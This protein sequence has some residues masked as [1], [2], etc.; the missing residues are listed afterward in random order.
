MAPSWAVPVGSLLGLVAVGL[1]FV[2]WFFPHAWKKG[3]QAERDLVDGL[4]EETRE[5]RIKYNRAIIKRYEKRLARERGE[6]VDDSD[7]D[8]EMQAPEPPP[9]AYVPT[10]H[11][12]VPAERTAGAQ[13]SV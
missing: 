6:F 7:D 12:K 8:L 5:A 4:P 3:T 10:E 2:A 1:I 9:P 11:S 13:E